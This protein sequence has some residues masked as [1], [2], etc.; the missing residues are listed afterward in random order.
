M[1]TKSEL[2]FYYERLTVRG[3]CLS[4]LNEFQKAIS[5]EYSLLGLV[6]PSAIDPENARHLSQSHQQHLGTFTE[7]ISE[8]LTRSAHNHNEGEEVLGRDGREAA[9]NISKS[10]PRLAVDNLNNARTA[11][12][13]NNS[14]SEIPAGVV[15]YDVLLEIPGLSVARLIDIGTAE[16][17]NL[18]SFKKGRMKKCDYMDAFVAHRE[19]VAQRSNT[20]IEVV[21]EE[22]DM[23]EDE[24]C[25]A[26]V[27]GGGNKRRRTT[28]AAN[29]AS[30]NV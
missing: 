9:P 10:R 25:G 18:K 21:E 17:V 3:L 30:E 22:C 24:A 6:R 12:S 7:Y 29:D 28:S 2:I 1:L 16:G 4:L 15:T 11:G 19:E 23:S 26:D 13:R 27:S 8:Q 20:E 5:S 14:E